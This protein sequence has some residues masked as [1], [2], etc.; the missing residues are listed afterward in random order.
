M[1]A[2]YCESGTLTLIYHHKI[3][4]IILYNTTFNEKKCIPIQIVW[5]IFNQIDVVLIRHKFVQKFD[6]QGIFLSQ[7]KWTVIL[8]SFF[9][10]IKYTKQNEYV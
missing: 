1:L 2:V 10:V 3:N 7:K 4:T 5:Y 8:F 9:P 6:V